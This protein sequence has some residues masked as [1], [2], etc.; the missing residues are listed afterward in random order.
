M[1]IGEAEQ[2]YDYE[3]FID[4]SIPKQ[5]VK[6][7]GETVLESATFASVPKNNS[8][9]MVG[10]GLVFIDTIKLYNA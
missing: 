9:F 3:L 4:S 10:Y 7:D 2:F 5:V 8:I 6:V 1:V